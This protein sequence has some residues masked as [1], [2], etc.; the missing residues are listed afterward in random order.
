MLRCLYVDLDGTL[1]GPDASLL[2]G[3]DRGFSLLGVRALEACARAGA[4]V[5]IYSGRKQSSVWEAARLIGSRAFIFELGCG[6]V[7]DGELEWLTDGLEPSS[8]EGSIFDQIS[9]SGA[10]SLLLERFGG[11]LE[12]HTPWSA[13]RDVS[14]LFRGSVSLDE[15]GAVLDAA[16]LGDRFRLLDNGVIPEARSLGLMP[17]L[18]VVRAYHLVPFGAS[19]GRAVA[20]HM[21]NRGYAASECIAVGDSREDLSAAGVVG[22]FWLVANALARDPGL[23]AEIAGRSDVRVCAEGYGAGVYEAVVT[24]LAEGR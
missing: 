20:R 21:Q 5:V 8:V 4:E 18:D 24:T 10:V 22:T 12:P 2:S 13:V 6:L 16:G 15:V 1:L 7:V 14:H 11:S 17:A 9:A 3:A 19:K 23:E